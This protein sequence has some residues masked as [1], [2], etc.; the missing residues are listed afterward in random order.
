MSLRFTPPSPP[1]GYRAVPDVAREL[2]ISRQSVAE[3]CRTHA[4]LA[5]RLDGRWYFDP[6]RLA[7]YLRQRAEG[8]TRVLR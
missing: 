1:P 3:W 7:A 5:L 2:G 4:G 8:G 6:D